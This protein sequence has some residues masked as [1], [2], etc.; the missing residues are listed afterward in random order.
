[1]DF[2]L[3]EYNRF[4]NIFFS[5]W[6]DG[7][8]HTNHGQ[9]GRKIVADLPGNHDLGLGNL[10]Q[11]PVRKR[12]NTYFG[13]GNRVDV[14]G[15]HSIVSVD[16]VSLTAMD[17]VDPGTGSQGNG[18]RA[19][20]DANAEIWDPVELFLDEVKE[21]KA[22][23]SDREIRSLNGDP[24]MVLQRHA[25]LD[26][27]STLDTTK[28]PKIQTQSLPTILLTHIPLFRKPGTPCGP[29]RER[30]PPSNPGRPTEKDDRNAIPYNA[31]YQYQNVLTPTVSKDLVDKIGDVVQVYSGDDH[32]YCE[33]DHREYSGKIKEITVKSIS[34]AMGV[35]KPG[36]Q[37]T[38]LWNPIDEKGNRR[39]SSAATSTTTIDNHLCLLPDQLGIF[40]RYGLLV[41]FTLITLFVRAIIVAISGDQ[42]HP[43]GFNSEPLLPNSIPNFL[44]P[45]P[46]SFPSSAEQEK[47][48]RLSRP[49]PRPIPPRYHRPL[50]TPSPL[51]P[52]YQDTSTSSAA[53]SRPVPR[54]TA[55]T[56]R[57]PR[58]LS[59]ANGNEN[60][61]GYAIPV[62]HK[63]KPDNF[64]PARH[65][66][67]VDKEDDLPGGDWDEWGMP[68]R[69]NRGLVG[70]VVEEFV[71][72]AAIVGAV[73]MAWYLWML[74]HS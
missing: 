49:S 23:A 24:E 71:T 14:I 18:A 67:V 39:S 58:D 57:T 37:M 15:N 29:L 19:R 45:N 64:G 17:Q 41:A 42:F 1:M 50:R 34:W 48:Q 30:W 10:I 74:R 8:A 9:R 31:G 33:V 27:E 63:D 3:T 36:F 28:A 43:H 26:L 60:G 61:S 65:A 52:N 62:S 56:S 38:S 72:S 25:V 6:N 44:N 4:G 20:D 35:R 47:A 2:W 12:F 21:R 11:G 5:L 70:K 53:E 55:A 59:P 13:D 69:K 66:H 22:R 16:T 7:G 51:N 68:R 32:D 73:A 40:I 46:A 54:S